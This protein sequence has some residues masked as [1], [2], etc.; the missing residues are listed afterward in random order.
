MDPARL[1][2]CLYGLLCVAFGVVLGKY[3]R[4]W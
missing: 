4:I 3:Q 1:V 2:F